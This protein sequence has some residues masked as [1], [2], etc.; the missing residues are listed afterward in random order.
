MR[1]CS[2]CFLVDLNK[3]KSCPQKIFLLEKSSSFPSPPSCAIQCWTATQEHFQKWK[4]HVDARLVHLAAG[5]VKV[6]GYSVFVYVSPFHFIWH[7]DNMPLKTSLF[8]WNSNSRGAGSCGAQEQC[9]CITNCKYFPS[10]IILSLRCVHKEHI[11]L[12]L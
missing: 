12:S 9:W 8:H 7:D 2:L 3:S 4:S 10:V 11:C 5:S 6:P 1:K